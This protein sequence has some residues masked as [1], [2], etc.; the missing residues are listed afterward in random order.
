MPDV[1]LDPAQVAKL[2]DIANNAMKA[3]QAKMAGGP[4]TAG[5]G[6]I[7]SLFCSDYQQGKALLTSF[8]WVLNLWPAGGAIASVVLA[9]L[10]SVGDALY[11][12]GC[13]QPGPVTPPAPP[14]A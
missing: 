14:P 12:Q 9:A 7:S 5:A 1:V 2:L 4:M 6:S 8:A 13:T 10:L 11:A 3:H